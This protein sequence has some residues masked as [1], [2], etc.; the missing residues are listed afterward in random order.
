MKQLAFTLLLLC[1]IL[2]SS[3]QDNDPAS[4]CDCAVNTMKKHPDAQNLLID[5]ADW[6]Y[7]DKFAKRCN[8]YLLSL[9]G[10]ELFQRICGIAYCENLTPSLREG[11]IYQLLSSFPND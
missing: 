6:E 8:K 2:T 5:V 4:A 9:P 3:A 1:P 11:I 7:D 10:T